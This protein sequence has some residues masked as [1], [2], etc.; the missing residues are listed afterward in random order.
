MENN[1]EHIITDG[2]WCWCFPTWDDGHPEIIIHHSASE[3]ADM[4]REDAKRFRKV[5]RR[6][7]FSKLC[8]KN[9]LEWLDMQCGFILDPD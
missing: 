9:S 5:I 1:K 3:L 2:D 8:I 6:A 7:Q 4:R